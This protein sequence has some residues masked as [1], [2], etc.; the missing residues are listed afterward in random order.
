MCPSQ[1]KDYYHCSDC[2]VSVASSGD[3]SPET[4]TA[5][6]CR[7]GRSC[8]MDLASQRKTV[9]SSRNDNHELDE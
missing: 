3:P 9:L 1:K 2:P 6:G 5:A 7:R 4:E 8:E